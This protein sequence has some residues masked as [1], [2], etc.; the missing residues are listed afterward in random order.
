MARRSSTA[1]WSGA[2]RRCR[3]RTSRPMPS[4]CWRWTRAARRSTATVELHVTYDEEAGGEIGPR[5]ILEEGLSKPDLAIGAGF[6]YAVVTAHNGCLHLEVEVLGRSA[7]AARPVHRRRRAGSGQRDPDRALRLARRA[8]RAD[9]EGS[10][11]RLAADDGRAHFR[12]RSTPMWCRTR[13]CSGSTAASSR[14]RTRPRSKRSCA[15]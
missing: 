7:H 2:A 14:R 9:V 5:W 11:H 12:R 6:S 1:G 4:P 13:S 8:R 15:R 10:R 3:S